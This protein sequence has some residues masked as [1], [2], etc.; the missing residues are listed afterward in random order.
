MIVG[1]DLVIGL[2]DVGLLP[3]WGLAEVVLL[4]Y[5]GVGLNLALLACEVAVKLLGPG[6]INLPLHLGVGHA[7]FGPDH[8]QDG[9]VLKHDARD[10][11]NLERLPGLGCCLGFSYDSGLLLLLLLVDFGIGV[12]EL[13]GHAVLLLLA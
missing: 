5:V 2:I 4:C 11:L 10:L 6:V 9:R 13:F 8:F 12:P 3:L 7:V 1:S